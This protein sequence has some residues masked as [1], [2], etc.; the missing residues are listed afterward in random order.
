MV[1][2]LAILRA[3]RFFLVTLILAGVA[4]AQAPANPRDAVNAQLEKLWSTSISE[5]EAQSEAWFRNLNLEE[6][7]A[8]RDA[9]LAAK[10]SPRQ[11]VALQ[12]LIKR[13]ARLDGP[14]A[15][16]F[17]RTQQAIPKKR[18]MAVALLGWAFSEPTKAWDE[19][20]LVSNRGADQSY[21]LLA[22]LEV[23]AE[24]NLD[25]GLQMYEDLLP[26]RACLDCCASQL[27]VAASRRGNFDKILAAI[28]RMPRGPTR[29]ALRD[30]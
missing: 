30:E 10:P 15:Y 13:W 4:R 21:N 6:T 20:M 25:L 19:L 1:D 24:N 18:A 11:E 29:D 14:A 7:L 26:D 27:M 2:V 28:A 8:A 9:L 5:I 17:A 23:I 3:G 12:V 16:D 22:I